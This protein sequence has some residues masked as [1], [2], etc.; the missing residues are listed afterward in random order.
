M[1]LGKKIAY[2]LVMMALAVGFTPV[3]AVAEESSGNEVSTP[4]GRVIIE[5]EPRYSE[6]IESYRQLF[7][8]GAPIVYPIVD[9]VV[10]ENEFITKNVREY[11]QSEVLHLQRGERLEL[12]I[13]VSQEGVYAIAFDYF[14]LLDSLVNIEF[15]LR[16]NDEIPFR[17]LQRLRFTSNWVNNEE[18]PTDRFG[19]EIIPTPQKVFEWQQ[20]ILLDSSYRDS[21]FLGLH[22]QEGQNLLTLEINEG[23][24][25]LGDVTLKSPERNL[26]AYIP[27]DVTGDSMIVIEAE[28]MSQRNASSIRAGA[29]FNPDMSPND[30]TKR[31]LN[32]LDGGSFTVPGQR[33]DYVFEVEAAGYYHLAFLYQA[34]HLIDFPVF[35]EIKINGEIPNHQLVSYPFPFTRD[36]TELIVS[37]QATGENMSFF[38]EEGENTLSLVVNIDP[39]G[40]IIER[41]EDML[42]EINDLVLEITRLTGGTQ[43]QNRTIDLDRF[44]P[45]A[46]SRLEGWA[47]ELEELHTSIVHFNPDVRR[48]GAFS[49]LNIASKT[50]RDLANE[51]NRLPVRVGE[52]SEGV[53]VTILASL[54]ESLNSSP[55]TLD[56]IF[57][58]QDQESLPQRST[59]SERLVL[60]TQRFFNSFSDAAFAP[61]SSSSE[62][63]QVWVNRPRQF[64]EIMQQM[65]D[66]YFTAQTG[67][68]VDFSIMPDPGRLTLA[69]AAG[70]AP[71]VA[72]SIT[73]DLPFEF[74]LRDAAV[75]LSQFT[76]FDDVIGQMAEGIIIPSMIGDGV[77][78]LPET[79]NFQVLFYRRDILESLN[80]PVPNTLDDVVEILP[81][82]Q[83]LGMNFFHPAATP[84]MR[85]LGSIMPIML[86]NGGSL[87][88][89]TVLNTTINSEESIA[90]FGQLTDLFSI[91]NIPYE[92]PN[93]YQHFRT[94]LIP[95]GIGNFETYILLLNAAPELV[96]LWEIALIPGVENEHG[97]VLRYS[98]GSDLTSMIFES[99][100]MQEE[101]W[102]YLQWWSSTETQVQFAERLQMTFG[103]EF[104]WLPANLEAFAELPW[105][106]AHRD[107]ILEQSQWIKDVPQVPGGYMLHR[108][109]SNAFIRTVLEG[110]NSRR[111]IDLTV[112]RTDREIARR[113]EEFGYLKNGEVISPFVTPSVE[114]SIRREE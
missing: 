99:S 83:R 61:Q 21:E 26:P 42:L 108:E 92:V 15:S 70:E 28:N 38:L 43:D 17:E 104:A 93:F 29:T 65:A 91:F 18:I 9:L 6:V 55:L 56:R 31:V 53:V 88:G 45:D 71:D 73:P 74:G 109:L 72:K 95:I 27:G 63:L 36:L 106:S 8:N 86:Q 41:I 23:N 89:E 7:F 11:H 85:S 5:Q 44:I 57:L 46:A 103:R 112:R 3:I 51:P 102:L 47:T 67:I 111:A 25:L 114:L 66:E 101:A 10:E 105:D 16:I 40:H 75:D 19:N 1:N 64:V 33:V 54:N 37:D 32:H 107:V 97:E 76:G 96:N 62:H 79:M 50:L 100:N 110:E 20:G 98:T 2:S 68:S 87:Y 69:N 58:F 48:I 77:Y 49:Q 4:A 60:N 80:I 13:D 52:L 90:G 82:L 22:L 14:D 94:G 84:G 81:D 59:F 113:L 39:I 34:P 35:R 78:S 12:H 30:S 24:F